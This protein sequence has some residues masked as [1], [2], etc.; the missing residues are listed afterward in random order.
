MS[1][2]RFALIGCG[3][4]SSRHVDALT[5][6]VSNAQIVA[7]CDLIPELAEKYSLR[8]AV[9][10]FTS[11]EK[12][13]KSVEV[14]CVTVA[15]PSGDH[16]HRTMEAL[17]YGKHVVAEK[18]VALRFDHVDE[19]ARTASG[20]NLRLWVAFQNRYNPAVMK[21]RAAVESGRFGRMV[22]G[23]VRV[24]WFRDQAYYDHDNWHGTWAMDGGVISQ[25]AIHHLD[26]LR[27]TMGEVESVEAQCATRLVKMECEDLCVANLR[28]KNGALGVVEAMTAAR[29]RDFEASLSLL[30]EKGTVIL[31]GLALNKVDVWEFAVPEEG[32]ERVP[33]TFSQEVPNAYGY[34][35]DVLYNRVVESILHGA[36][37]EISGEEGRKALE[38]VH[39]I[40]ASH[41]Q[42]VRV[43]MENRPTSSRLGVG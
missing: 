16:Y 1:Q 21:A 29:P 15:T 20:R 33:E 41:E 40:Y 5:N 22:I 36:P 7:V 13:Y 2:V 28:F 43:D 38:L 19:M 12:M 4:V 3:R 37:V 8:L 23:T 42:G 34:G 24:R 14:D 18:P 25:Q 27:W 32:D 6:K 30:G 26:A 11:T 17:S 9:P 35:H 31:G 10:G 39:A